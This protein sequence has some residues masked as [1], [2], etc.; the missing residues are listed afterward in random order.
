MLGFELERGPGGK[1][2]MLLAPSNETWIRQI[3][4]A[5]RPQPQTQIPWPRAEAPEIV[6]RRPQEV[7]LRREGLGFEVVTDRQRGPTMFGQV[8]CLSHSL[9]PPAAGCDH[10]PTVLPTHRNQKGLAPQVIK[11]SPVGPHGQQDHPP[12]AELG[13]HKICMS[14]AHNWVL[15]PQV[16]MRDDRVT[17]IRFIGSRNLYTARNRHG[18]VMSRSSLGNYQIVLSLDFV[19][20]RRLCPD[21]VPGCPLPE[22]TRLANETHRVQV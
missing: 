4:Q 9:N 16:A 17:A 15:Q 13:L 2:H 22:H 21:C 18:M 8:R 7:P 6:A 12:L 10:R 20:V 14:R 11:V 19:K 5:L 1:A 3:R